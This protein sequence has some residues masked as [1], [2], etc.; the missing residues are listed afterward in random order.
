MA[1]N[2]LL[3]YDVN[4][5]NT[6]SFLTTSVHIYCMDLSCL[7]GDIKIL[8]KEEKDRAGRFKFEH[9]RKRFIAAHSGLRKI[10]MKYI[11]ENPAIL[12]DSHGKPYLRDYP[13]I[14][15]NLT[16]SEEMALCALTIDI[17]LGIDVEYTNKSHDILGISEKF[18]AREEFLNIQSSENPQQLFFQYWTRKEAYLKAKGIGIVNGLDQKIP[19]EVEIHDFIPA[20]NYTASLCLLTKGNDDKRSLE[21]F[22]VAD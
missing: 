16:H 6:L 4:A 2:E 19:D 10:L 7:N 15:F 12:K 20:P 8:D 9:H 14:Q 3:K 21:K 1:H 5:M 18:F 22:L 11:P 13:E 17:P